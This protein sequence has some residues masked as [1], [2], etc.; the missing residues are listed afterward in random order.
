[1]DKA[2]P[3][4]T[5]EIQITR[6]LLKKLVTARATQSKLYLNMMQLVLIADRFVDLLVAFVLPLGKLFLGKFRQL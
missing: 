5:N 6:K 2:R 4:A 1:M 3:E